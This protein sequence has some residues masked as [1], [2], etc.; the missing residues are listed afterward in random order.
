MTL[1]RRQ[2]LKATLLGT[3]AA[4]V[5]TIGYS[6]MLSTPDPIVSQITI[7]LPE[8]PKEFIG[9]K[10]AFLADIHIGHYLDQDY[11]ANVIDITKK[12]KPDIALFGG[13]YIWIER[14]LL[15]KSLVKFNH[16]SLSS[17]SA[18]D[19]IDA[20]F[21]WCAKILSNLACPDGLY[22]VLGNHDRWE[23][24][25]LC[26]N[27]FTEFK[28][29]MLI[30]NQEKIRRGAANLSIIG[31][32]D[33]W[34]GIPKL[35]F[36]SPN[37]DKNDIRILLS[38]NPDFISEVNK[39]TNFEFD[40]ALCGHTHGG[41]IKLPLMGPLIYNIRSHELFE[42]LVPLKAKNHPPYVF[43]TRGIGMVEVPIRINCPPEIAI[44]T[45]VA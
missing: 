27:Y 35:G 4:A 23:N 5:G 1:S 7:R 9:Y 32:D 8:L 43:T 37:K 36:L 6:S 2:F 31:V 41:Q 44:L 33:Y 16:N 13:D 25:A 15:A 18:E 38:H 11:L 34:T 42:G 40:L 26:I 17:L 45:L 21:K 28:I 22:A 29:K 10:I 24:P 30:N 3:G 12:E 39:K 14:S 19:L 20:S